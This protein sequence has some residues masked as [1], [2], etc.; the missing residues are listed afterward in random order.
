V[1]RRL[2][3]TPS[4]NPFIQ[5]PWAY[6]ENSARQRAGPSPEFVQRY[7]YG[8][9]EGELESEAVTAESEW[10]LLAP[11]PGICQVSKVGL[12]GQIAEKANA[13]SEPEYEKRKRD[14]RP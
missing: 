2:M 12:T 11:W 5:R 1:K 14:S 8:G 3:I 7:C 13:S 10:W 9:G 6:T 4:Q